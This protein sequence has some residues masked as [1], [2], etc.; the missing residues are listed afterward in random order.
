MFQWI[1]GENENNE[2]QDK[3]KNQ[4]NHKNKMNKPDV[5][6]FSNE[7]TNLQ[8]REK[9]VHKCIPNI[10]FLLLQR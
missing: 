1:F 10:I 4:S 6:T 2:N 8:K 9:G 7:P 3:K 5:Y